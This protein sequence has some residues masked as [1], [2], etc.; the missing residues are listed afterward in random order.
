MKVSRGE[1][2]PPSVFFWG[3]WSIVIDSD[4]CMELICILWSFASVDHSQI[5]NVSFV[6][7]WS[8]Q[9]DGDLGVAWKPGILHDGPKRDG[10]KIERQRSFRGHIAPRWYR[11]SSH[12]NLHFYQ[13]KWPR[14]L[15]WSYVSTIFQVICWGF[16]SPELHR[17]EISAIAIY[18]R[19]LLFRPRFLRH[20]HWF[21]GLL[22]T[23]RL[24]MFEYWRVGLVRYNG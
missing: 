14:I 23:S 21:L 1:W 19:Y 13:W 6:R 2:S 5:L 17:P 7:H 18:G 22:G 16:L 15:K 9:N 12:W 24:A 20:G 10:P 11:G 4:S 8:P 3:W